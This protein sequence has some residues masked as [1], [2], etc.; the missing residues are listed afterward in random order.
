MFLEEGYEIVEEIFIVEE[1]FVYLKFYLFDED[2]EEY[3]KFVFKEKIMK[4]IDLYKGFKF[5]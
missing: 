3:E 5:Y 4:R 2:I 1:E